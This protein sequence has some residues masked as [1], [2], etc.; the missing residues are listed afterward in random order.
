MPLRPALVAR[1]ADDRQCIAEM[2]RGDEIDV[3]AGGYRLVVEAVA[4]IGEIGIGEGEN[5]AAVTMPWPLTMSCRTFMVAIAPPGVVLAMTM[6]RP[7]AAWS[8]GHMMAV[9]RSATCWGVSAISFPRKG[10]GRFS[11]KAATPSR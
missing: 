11:M 6:P 10:A 1:A 5:E 4:G 3:Y 2:G 9:Q 8:S 7:C